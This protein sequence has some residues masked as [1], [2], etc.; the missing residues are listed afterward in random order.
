[1]I[2]FTLIHRRTLGRFRDLFTQ[3]VRQFCATTHLRHPYSFTNQSSIPFKATIT[4]FFQTITNLPR[5]CK[6]VYYFGVV[7]KSI[8]MPFPG[9]K[10]HSNP[11][12]ANFKVKIGDVG[13]TLDFCA[14]TQRCLGAY[15]WLRS[16]DRILVVETCMILV[17]STN[18]SVERSECQ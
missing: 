13:R 10:R 11:P 5:P 6:L 15:P 12:L 9:Q 8:T 4:L 17:K 3:L 1:M 18:L 16:I 14:R 7:H 2:R